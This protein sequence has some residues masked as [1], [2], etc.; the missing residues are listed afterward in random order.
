MGNPWFV[1][2]PWEHTSTKWG[3][4]RYSDELAR[5]IR[6]FPWWGRR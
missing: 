6:I 1:I 4:Y 2:W 3:L 5:S